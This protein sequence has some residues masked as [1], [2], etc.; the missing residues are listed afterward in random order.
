VLGFLEKDSAVTVFLAGSGGDIYLVKQGDRFADDLLV[1][2]LDITKIVI[3]RGMDD[4][5]V[6]LKVS[7]PKVQRMEMRGVPSG[8]PDVPVLDAQGQENP[9]LSAE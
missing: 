2:E 3:S 6:T 4:Q 5:G 8:R 7:E 1:R 9:A